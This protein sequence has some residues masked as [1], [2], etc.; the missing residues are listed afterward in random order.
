MRISPICKIAESLDDVKLLSRAVT[1][2]S[3]NHEE[4]IKGAEATAVAAYL[5]RTGHD[6]EQIRNYI[7]DH[8]YVLDFTLERLD[9]GLREV[10]TAFC[11]VY[12]KNRPPH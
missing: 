1:E 8:Y 9:S 7:K 3:H 10:V 2:I 5:A 4:G 12:P 11:L 6:K